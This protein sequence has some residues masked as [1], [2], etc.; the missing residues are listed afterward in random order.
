MIVIIYKSIAMRVIGILFIVMIIPV[1]FLTSPD[2][3]RAGAVSTTSGVGK[4]HLKP[5]GEIAI[6]LLFFFYIAEEVGYAN[7]IPTYAFKAGVANEDE[8]SSLA[9]IFWIVNTIA[10]LVLL[11]WTGPIAYRLKILLRFLVA[12]TLMVVF[13]QMMGLYLIVSYVGVISSGICLSA[14]Y[15]LFFSIAI[16]YGYYLSPSNTAN[17]AMS[18]SMGE[19]LLV[20]PIGYAMGFFGIEALIIII[21]IMSAVMMFIFEYLI[22]HLASDSTK[23]KEEKLIALEEIP[24]ET[25]ANF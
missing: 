13:L 3:K 6:C 7:W 11:Y 5:H 1:F 17:F 21:F 23:S 9:S 4:L 14:M 24:P 22:A 12:S 18:A 8:A 20:M 16:D 2:K 10:R 15:A 19:G 25:L